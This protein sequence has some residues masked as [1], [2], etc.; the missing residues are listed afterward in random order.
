MASD[1]ANALTILT[2][3]L[4]QLVPGFRKAIKEVNDNQMRLGLEL[5]A[6]GMYIG[7]LSAAMKKN[8]AQA[9]VTATESE[10]WAQ[11]VE[12]LGGKVVKTT[13]KLDGLGNAAAKVDPKIQAM[14]DRIKEATDVLQNA[15]TNALDDAKTRLSDANKSFGDFADSVSGGIKSAF[16]FKDAKDSG[17]ETGQGFLAGLQTQVDGIKLYGADIDTL[18]KRGLS[19]DALKAVLDAGGESGAAIA[20]ELVLGAQENITGPAGVNALVSSANEVANQ[21]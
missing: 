21:I 15:L 20:H 1:A 10:R 2:M 5:Q 17:K 14:K 6:N 19:Q 9:K 4:V 12:N 8:A 13:G 3:G 18:L 16:S 7:D 11:Y